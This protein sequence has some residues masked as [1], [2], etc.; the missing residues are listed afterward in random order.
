MDNIS[1]Q[2]KFKKNCFVSL[3]QTIVKT[4]LNFHSELVQPF[5]EMELK[6]HI[7]FLKIQLKV[8]TNEK[9]TEGHWWVWGLIVA[10]YLL[11]LLLY[12]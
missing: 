10:V 9:L 5:V 11:L 3:V 1:Q 8:K 12:I 7:N 2:T 6:C 4:E